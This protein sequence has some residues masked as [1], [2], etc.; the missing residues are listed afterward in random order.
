MTRLYQTAISIPYSGRISRPKISRIVGL[1]YF[2]EN[3]FAVCSSEHVDWERDKHALHSEHEYEA[4][5][6]DSRSFFVDNIFADSNK[7]A[8][9]A[10]IFTRKIFP[11][12]QCMYIRG[13]AWHG[14]PTNPSTNHL[15][16][17][18]IKDLGTSPSLARG[19][20][21]Q[22]GNCL[23]TPLCGILWRIIIRIIKLR[24]STHTTYMWVRL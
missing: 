3:I 4:S 13:V 15:V 1:G 6:N 19:V 17:R 5:G 21:G 20:S 12:I 18:P 24:L 7:N 10:K 16:P 11:T 23:D 8:K 22:R 14:C 2:A 9:S